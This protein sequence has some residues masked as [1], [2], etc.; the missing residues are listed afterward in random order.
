[1]LLDRSLATAF[2]VGATLLA[3]PAAASW[4]IAFVWKPQVAPEAT[5]GQRMRHA[6]TMSIHW[7]FKD[8]GNGG[9]DTDNEESCVW[10]FD[11][12]I[13]A[14]RRGKVSKERID[15][16]SWE[17]S[18]QGGLPDGSLAGRTI[19]VTHGR[20][21][22]ATVRG[23][24]SRNLSEG[25]QR[26]L[27]EW[28]VSNQDP[29]SYA[30]IPSKDTRVGE[31]WNIDPV[32]LAVAW[33]LYE[34]SSVLPRRSTA[35][36]RLVDVRLVGDA[37][38]GKI[39]V[40]AEIHL[41]KFPKTQLKFQEGGVF[42]AKMTIEGPLEPAIGIV[43]RVTLAGALEGNAVGVSRGGNRLTRTVKLSLDA[44]STTEGLEPATPKKRKR[45]R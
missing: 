8:I 28:V 19:D 31:A 26:W 45:K 22:V 15:V 21:Q 11:R 6:G 14:A 17:L 10:K 37:H 42:K 27:T 16:E 7:V 29:L 30:A 43:R 23:I 12:E 13:V 34:H 39:E 1:M 9:E 41:G 24:S 3:V 35:K 18:D 4:P 20:R 25:A 5:R 32:K 44:T 33:R 40:D 38:V 2:V 36:G